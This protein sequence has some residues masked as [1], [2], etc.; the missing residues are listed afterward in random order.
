MD[1]Y[2]R[3][4]E[5][6]DTEKYI[7]RQIKT[8]IARSLYDPNKSAKIW[9]EDDNTYQKAIEIINNTAMFKKMKIDF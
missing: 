9:L 3:R 1:N 5:N 7:K 8:L 2:T 6:F 4:Q